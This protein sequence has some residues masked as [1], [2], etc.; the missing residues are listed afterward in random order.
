MKD[1]IFQ[2]N[3]IHLGFLSGSVVKNPQANAADAG[4]MGLIPGL[5]RS[6]E[7]GNGNLPQY[8]CMENPMDRGYLAGYSPWGRKQVDTT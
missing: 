7:E 8:P 6:P 3:A 4:G 5:G 1:N 2:M